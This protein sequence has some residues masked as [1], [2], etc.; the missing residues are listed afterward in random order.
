[1]LNDGSRKEALEQKMQEIVAQYMGPEIEFHTGITMDQGGVG[2]KV[3]F[4]YIAQGHSLPLYQY[5]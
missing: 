3:V 1:V 5:R 4:I 2:N